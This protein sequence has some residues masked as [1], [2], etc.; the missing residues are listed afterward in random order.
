MTKM[1][2]LRE[3]IYKLLKRH[4]LSDYLFEHEV[5]SLCDLI[6]ALPAIARILALL[7]KEQEGYEVVVVD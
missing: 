3:Q 1:D 4:R 2:E 6:L 5:D 7:E